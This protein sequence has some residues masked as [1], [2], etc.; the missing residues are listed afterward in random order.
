MQRNTTKMNGLKRRWKPVGVLIF[1]SLFLM[2]FVVT[3]VYASGLDLNQELFNQ[4]RSQIENHSFEIYNNDWVVESGTFTRTM[5]EQHDGTW[6]MRATGTGP[7]VLSQVLDG[8]FSNQLSGR[9]V[10]FN[11]WFSGGADDEA[12]AKIQYYIPDTSD[13]GDDDGGGSS[14]GIYF[15]P[16]SVNNPSNP[17]IASTGWNTISGVSTPRSTLGG[18]GWVNVVVEGEIPSSATSVKLVI[19]L[20]DSSLSSYVDHADIFMVRHLVNDLTYYGAVSCT[21]TL[22]ISVFQIYETSSGQY[23]A[24]IGVAAGGKAK[25]ADLTIKEIKI[26]IEMLPVKWWKSQQDGQV[27]IF[28]VGQGNNLGVVVHPV[29]QT[30][31]ATIALKVASWAIGAAI[32]A[33]TGGL[34][35]LAWKAVGMIAGATI[36]KI[37]DYT[38][39]QTSGLDTYAEGGKFANYYTQIKWKY[40]L[41]DYPT[42]AIGVNTFTW[43]FEPGHSD[44]QLMVESSVTWSLPNGDTSTHSHVDYIDA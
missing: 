8:E 33:V 19:E 10:Q 6:S 4:G 31:G 7:A 35:G 32:G 30:A 42:S 23:L 44:Y 20:T 39:E 21:Q 11:F 17:K 37:F 29:H 2:M 14:G 18:D 43:I 40:P 24:E 22:T 15:T 38:E 16:T 26:R 12:K 5:L 13:D 34:G 9:N 3:P 27:N 1:C 36:S 25:I 28:D 41:G